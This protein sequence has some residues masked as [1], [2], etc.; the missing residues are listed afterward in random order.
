MGYG[1]WIM[2]SAD[3]RK[4]N[5]ATGKKV[6]LG[7]GRSFFFDE[8]IFLGNPRMAA[9]KD[10]DCVWVPNYP[11]H[12]PY[13]A[14]VDGQKKRMIFNDDYRPEPGEIWFSEEEEH[15]AD[16]VAPKGD[17]IVVEANVKQMYAHTV[18]KAWR[19]D[20]WAEVLKSGLPFIQ[21]GE[22]DSDIKTKTFRQAM[23]I[24]SRATMFVGT[25]GGLHHAAAA[26][27]VPAVVIWT[28]FT[29]PKHLGYDSHINIHDGGDPCGYYGGP[30]G[31]CAAIAKSITPDRV[32]STIG[33][34]FEKHSRYLA[35]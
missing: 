2:A 15:W 27:N 1:D 4:A 26:L 25:D 22:K 29:S 24:L 28:G 6:K 7:D 33:E 12:R 35:T 17:F 32:L 13:I 23:L 16:Q 34:E 11:R 18:N 20:Y 21:L 8:Q 30:C 9:K 5:Q 19:K 14:A 3:V 31:H 10:M